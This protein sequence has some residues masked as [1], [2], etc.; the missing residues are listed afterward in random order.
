MD[1][2]RSVSNTIGHAASVEFTFGQVIGK[3]QFNIR[4]TQYDD[5][6]FTKPPEGCLQYFT[7]ATGKGT[8]INHI[9]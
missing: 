5:K 2:G 1:V 7:G 8:F 6:S 9:M 3:R 4:V